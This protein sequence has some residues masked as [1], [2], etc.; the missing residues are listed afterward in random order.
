MNNSILT[1]DDRRGYP[2]VPGNQL[3]ARIG[4]QLVE[5]L[6][7]SIG[8]V[9]LAR[10][11]EP[12][13]GPLSLTLFPRAGEKLDLNRGVRV[14]GSVI[15]VDAKAVAVDFAATSYALAK[16]VVWHASG[17]LGATPHLVK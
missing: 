13:L 15:R 3:M 7:V 2:R 8:G 12:L 1:K 4:T 16:L 5:V 6:D 14:S 11:F 17:K 10:T 9:K